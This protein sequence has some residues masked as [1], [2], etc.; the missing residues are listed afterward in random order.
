MFMD[1]SW[2]DLSI[3]LR[4]GTVSVSELRQAR[5]TI[6]CAR[7]GVCS[8]IAMVGSKDM[9]HGNTITGQHPQAFQRVVTKTVGCKY[10]LFLPE[11]YDTDAYR[12]PLILF[13]HGAGER[14]ANLDLVKVHGLPRL[15]DTRHDFPFIVV[16]PQ[17]P[18]DGWWSNDVLN[19]L[20][21]ETVS[22]YE[23]DEDRIYVTGLSMGGYGTW[24][25]AIEYPHRFAAIAPICGGGIPALAC[26]VK[27]LPVWVF[28]GAE[29][30]VVP[31][32]E[33]ERMV[34]SLKECRGNVKFTVYPDA[35]H[36]SW[37]PTYGN[38]ALYSWFL[39]NRRRSG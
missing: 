20:L 25:L 7:T 11:R 6:A 17:C 15:L 5:K 23:V 14:G 10:L 30:D 36:D 19:A 1:F 8:A 34:N 26:R 18:Q 2:A 31:L 38:P 12:W 32:T 9:N 16:S 21:E 27:D 4:N 37:T 29:D 39:E 22:R 24:S 13:L 33:S 28:H 35:G 3:I